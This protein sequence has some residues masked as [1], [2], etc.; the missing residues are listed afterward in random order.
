MTDSAGNA[1][2]EVAAVSVFVALL[3]KTLSLFTADPLSGAALVLPHCAVRESLDLSISTL[4]SATQCLILSFLGAYLSLRAPFGGSEAA[5]CILLSLA[6]DEH[7]SGLVGG[8]SS[9]S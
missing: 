7:L 8:D 2:G 3:D 9:T 4:S 5:C 6:R 1:F